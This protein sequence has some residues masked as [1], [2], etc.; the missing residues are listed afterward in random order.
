L[1]KI[2]SLESFVHFH[3]ISREVERER[4][5]KRV[6]K[7]EE[8]GSKKRVETQGIEAKVKH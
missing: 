1:R 6:L 3:N 2:R 7:R 4:A 5:R 8:L